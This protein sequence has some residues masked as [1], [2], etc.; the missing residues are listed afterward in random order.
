MN[1]L[2]IQDLNPDEHLSVAIAA[3][4]VASASHL[5]D[6]PQLMDYLVKALRWDSRSSEELTKDYVA[7]ENAAP[8]SVFRY[9]KYSPFRTKNA[10]AD[11]VASAFIY[12]TRCALHGSRPKVDYRDIS[13]YSGVAI[14]ASTDAILATTDK[15][16]SCRKK[17][18]H[19][20]LKSLLPTVLAYKVNKS[21]RPF[22]SA[23]KIL[24]LLEGKDKLQFLF[25][26]DIL[27]EALNFRRPKPR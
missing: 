12:L 5:N 4:F 21:K 22:N 20:N 26:L 11:A 27:N 3:T 8:D 14:K 25:N 1:L 7:A 16:L 2:T 9:F 6:I 13:F 17:F 15:T 19:D 24:D 10:Q 23:E 18:A